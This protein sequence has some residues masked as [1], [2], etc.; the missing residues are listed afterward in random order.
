MGEF[1][2]ILCCRV[3]VLS[4]AESN[5]CLARDL[6]RIEPVSGAG[7]P[8]YFISNRFG[9]RSDLLVSYHSVPGLRVRGSSSSMLNN[10]E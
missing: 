3:D 5:R 1:A 10:V 6:S 7:R 2:V 4:L 8:K 9:Q